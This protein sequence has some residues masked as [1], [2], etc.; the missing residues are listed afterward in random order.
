MAVDLNKFKKKVEK[1]LPILFLVEDHHF[2][3]SFGFSGF[4]DLLKFILEVCL[5]RNIHTEFMVISY[6]QEWVLQFP[7][8]KNNNPCYADL[9]NV[10]LYDLKS[11]INGMRGSAQTFLGSTLELSKAILDDPETT[12]SD[13]Y[14]PIVMVVASR[15]PAKGW[16]A[17]LE[18]LLND[19]RSSNAQF[20]WLD[21]TEES[22]PSLLKKYEKVACRN[23]GNLIYNWN[24]TLAEE[25]VSTFKFEPLEDVPEEAPTEFTTPGFN[26]S[27][28]DGTEAKGDGVV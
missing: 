2:G 9:E 3:G 7:E 28:G 17:P 18:A 11:K 12:K 15:E 26:G 6:G 21:A 27:F 4:G 23:I 20:I 8:L 13:R 22:K 1:K 16:E 25:I 10:D 24:S 14:K 19:G 5:E